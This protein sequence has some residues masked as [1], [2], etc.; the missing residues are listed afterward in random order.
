MEQDLESHD[1]IKYFTTDY[2]IMTTLGNGQFSVVKM[3][4]H[5]PTLTCV[6][7][8]F[9]KN[10]KKYSSVI[11]TEVNI[12]KSL[13]HPNIIKVFQVVQTRENTYL[14]M[15]HASEGDL[16]NRIRECG[17]LKSWDAR[18]MFRQILEAVQY[19]HD[20]NIVHRNIKASNIL[21]D[22][23]WNAK[24]CDFGLAVQTLPGQKLIEFCGTLPYCA[25]E[26]FQAE[27]YEGRPV[28]IWS[29][30]VLLFF[31]V[32]GRLP[33]LGTSFADVRRQITAANFSIPPHV[34]ND[35]FNVIVEMLMINPSRRPP[36]TKS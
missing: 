11:R 34:A 24:L 2:K 30:G 26:F 25:P 9:F 32:T 14:V 6:A 15:E 13:A 29:M 16:L 20:N 5:I 23:R 4:Y 19:C 3:A 10:T 8:K 22:G 17:F 33:F 12:L 1:S 18:R 36:S 35:I 27:E 31:M 7:I 28:D 21:L